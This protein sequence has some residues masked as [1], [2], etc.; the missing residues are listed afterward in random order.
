MKIKAV[1]D[2][3]DIKIKDAKHE[4]ASFFLFPYKFSVI[5]KIATTMFIGTIKQQVAQA[6]VSNL[7][8]SLQPINDQ[9]NNWFARY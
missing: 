5:D 2:K 9:M 4:Y 7:A 8:E 1:I 6:I 3:M